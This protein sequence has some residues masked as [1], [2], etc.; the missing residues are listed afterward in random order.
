MS[1]DLILRVPVLG[2]S[3]IAFRRLTTGVSYY[4]KP[5]ADLA[6]WLV[7]SRETTNFT[8]DLDELNKRYLAAFVAQITNTDT[9]QVEGYLD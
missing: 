3:W 2:R 6:T 7:R 1:R 4:R 9:T 5:L 8:Y